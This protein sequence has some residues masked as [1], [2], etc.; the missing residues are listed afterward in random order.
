MQGDWDRWKLQPVA[1]AA[2][3]KKS[4]SPYSLKILVHRESERPWD[5]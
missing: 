4:S 1:I 3:L 5:Q 2:E